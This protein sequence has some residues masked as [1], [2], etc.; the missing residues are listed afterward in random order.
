MVG[1]ERNFRISAKNVLLTYPQANGEQYSIESLRLFLLDAAPHIQYYTICEERHDDEGRHFHAFITFARKFS[2]RNVRI[3]DWE[4]KHPNIDT[5]I[6]SIRNSI[7]YCKKDGNFVT[8]HPEPIAKQT[9]GDILATATTAQEAID[10]IKIWY[11]RDWVLYG[12]RL[13]TNLDNHYRAPQP[14]YT[15][16]ENVRFNNIPGLADWLDNE[17]CLLRT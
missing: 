15:T 8:T 9:Y 16:P 11:P 17:V 6:R 14:E 2:S 3:F 5:A 1:A 13:R 10:L 7:T 12:D 4:G